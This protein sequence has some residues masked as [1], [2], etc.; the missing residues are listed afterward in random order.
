M[1]KSINSTCAKKPEFLCEIC[2]NVFKNKNKLKIHFNSSCS[3]NLIH[4][5]NPKNGGKKCG[6]SFEVP[7]TFLELFQSKF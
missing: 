7:I 4:F 6:Q 5:G 2:E 1:D 3:R